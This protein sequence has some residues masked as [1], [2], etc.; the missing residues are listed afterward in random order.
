MSMSSDEYAAEEVISELHQDAIMKRATLEQCI[1]LF[2]EGESEEEAFPI[3]LD[4][5]GLDLERIGVVIANYNGIGNLKNSLRLLS[6]TLSYNRP[7]IV[8]FDNDPAGMQAQSS[9]ANLNIN[10]NLITMMP[11][12]RNPVVTY[13]NG[14]QGGSYEEIF[15]PAYFITTCFKYEIIGNSL[16]SKKSDFEDVFDL[17]KP[18]YS[19]VAKFCHL[20]NDQYFT[21]NKIKLAITLAENC[22]TVPYT[23]VQLAELLLDVRSRHPVRHP[24]DVNLPKILGLTC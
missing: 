17:D 10:H 5:Y 16:W 24:D 12:P 14:H 4:K 13:A 1:Y 6:Q 18:W 3:L 22:K 11:I 8:T 9:I 20:N 21:S 23:V 15:E 2:V 7:I 19:Q